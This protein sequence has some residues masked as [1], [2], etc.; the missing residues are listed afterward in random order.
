MTFAEDREYLEN[1]QGGSKMS[2]DR[3]E[4]EPGGSKRRRLDDSD[5]D[6]V[7]ALRLQLATIP[8]VSSLQKLSHNCIIFLE[9]Q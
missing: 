1:Y 9:P 7:C 4:R 5:E 3:G 2:S 8:F 6:M